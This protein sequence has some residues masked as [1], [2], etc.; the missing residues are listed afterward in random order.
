MS[1]LES[2]VKNKIVNGHCDCMFLYNTYQWDWTTIAALVA[3]RPL[4]FANS[5]NDSIF[6]MDGNRRVIAQLRRLYEMYGQPNLV[7]DYVSAGGHAYRPD[8]RVAIFKFLNR[9]LKGDATTPVEDCAK[10]APLEGRQLRVFPDEA[11]LPKDAINVRADEFFIPR[12]K[13][14]LPEEGKFKEW[15]KNL[16][17]E[18]R[19]KSFAALPEKITAPKFIRETPSQSQIL[20]TSDGRT[21][22]INYLAYGGNSRVELILG[23]AKQFAETD[24]KKL[25]AALGIKLNAEFLLK[26]NF[27]HFDALDAW[28]KKSPPNYHERSRALLGSTFD[29]DHVHDICAVAKY[30]KKKAGVRLFGKGQDGIRAAYAAL[31]EPS[32]KE[33]VIIDPPKSHMEGPHFLNVLRILDIPEALGLLAPMP[34][35]IIGDSDPAFDRTEEIYRLAGAEG[36]LKR[37]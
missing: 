22:E 29:T 9:H 24:Q 23:L 30:C 6:P 28:E 11:D 26:S 35:T 13:V 1:D 17:A 34:L 33:V 5:D 15:K 20:E 27:C 16:L 18:L 3:P 4:L 36:K 31:L 32:I 21:L 2:Y 19:K 14:A 37:K 25:E 10:Y 7:D 12:A 8:L